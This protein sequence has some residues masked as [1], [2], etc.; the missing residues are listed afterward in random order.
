ME[1]LTLFRGNNKEIHT[2]QNDSRSNGKARGGQSVIFLWLF[3]RRRP[4]AA[5]MGVNFD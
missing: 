1:I 5:D 2:I 3:Q 4:S